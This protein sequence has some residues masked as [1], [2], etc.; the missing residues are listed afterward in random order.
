MRNQ[1]L[2]TFIGLPGPMLHL[3][4]V[5]P[6]G[7]EE[8]WSASRSQEWL[9]SIL[10]RHVVQAEIF[11]HAWS[12]HDVVLWDQ[13]RIMHINPPVE[14]YAPERRIHHRIRL[15]ASPGNRPVGV[16]DRL[17]GGSRPKL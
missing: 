3:I 2:R 10:R 14:E 8:A 7:S 12:P 4:E 6:D 16:V 13:R 17:R 9:A 1:G 11:A 15:D 5:R